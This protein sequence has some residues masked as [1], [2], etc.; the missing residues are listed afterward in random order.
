MP[1]FAWLMLLLSIARADTVVLF[2]GDA[3]D[4][5]L[6]ARKALRV[7]GELS[8]HRLVELAPG[9]TPYVIGEP[10]GLRCSPGRLINVREGVEN[11]QASLARS[12][13]ALGALDLA[14]LDLECLGE[15]VDPGLAA[16]LFYLR[17]FLS[18]RMGNAANAE[19]SFYR[20]FLFSP[21]ITWDVEQGGPRPPEAFVHAEARARSYDSAW[22]RVI[23]ALPEGFS[24][25][26]DGQPREP[27][28]GRVPLKPGVHL[29]QVIADGH[30]DQP[31]VVPL[32]DDEEKVLVLPLALSEAMLGRLED[33]EVRRALG[34]LMAATWPDQTVVVAGPTSTW[35]FDSGAGVWTA[36]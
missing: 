14:R 21:M 25:R 9:A 34:L 16:Q 20:A 4:A 30:V 3:A 6:R 12:K 5:E 31:L 15:P 24:L 17:G 27:E 28:Q 19:S 2:T 7:K 26:I 29:I 32:Q 1:M 22:L 13:D 36:R 18:W 11:A 8:M 33:E 10:P 23:P 35:T